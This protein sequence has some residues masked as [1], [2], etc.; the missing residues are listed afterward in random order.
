MPK[1]SG[2]KPAQVQITITLSLGEVSTLDGPVAQALANLAGVMEVQS[3]DG[4]YTGGS[5][6]AAVDDNE[7]LTDLAVVSTTVSHILSKG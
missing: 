2:A 3:E 7:Y 4:L 6:D 1:S 5:P